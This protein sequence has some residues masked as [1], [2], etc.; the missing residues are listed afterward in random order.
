MNDATRLKNYR[1][2][3][4][5][6]VPPTSPGAVKADDPRMIRYHK[7]FQAY[8][9]RKRLLTECINGMTALVQPYPKNPKACTPTA[10]FNTHAHCYERK[11]S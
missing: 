11:A 8:V 5:S 3:L 1:E 10:E 7:D 4:A 9:N 6:L 2:E